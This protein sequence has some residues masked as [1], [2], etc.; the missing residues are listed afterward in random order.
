MTPEQTTLVPMERTG[1]KASD[2]YYT[3]G[4]AIASLL[5]GDR[6]PPR[7]L[8]VIEPCA[9]RGDIVR[10]L[11]GRGYTVDA[12]YEIREEEHEPLRELL[13]P[14]VMICDALLRSR[15]HLRAIVTN[16]P[17]SIGHEFWVWSSRALYAAFLVRLNVLGS[18]T[19]AWAWS[20][21]R[22]TFLRTLKQRPSFRA[23]GATDGAEYG[24]LGWREGDPPLD[25]TIV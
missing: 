16:P 12:A 22:P 8:P 2:V 20:A 15:P 21:R 11:Q 10:A 18:N 19:W 7:D 24:W 1:V 25:F 6:A 14:R 3:P 9:G 4:S 23:D 17:F 5:D 13:G